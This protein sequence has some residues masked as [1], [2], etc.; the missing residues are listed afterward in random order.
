MFC[1]A[2]KE[3]NSDVVLKKRENDSST[4]IESAGL[5]GLLATQVARTDYGFMCLV[6]NTQVKSVKSI[7]RHLRDQHL[8]EDW[9]YMCPICKKMYRNQSSLYAHI[10]VYHP[11]LKGLASDQ[12]RVRND[13]S[14]K[15]SLL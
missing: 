2:R 11:D 1:A 9:S 13:G 14:E 3:I 6:C 4:I 7:R 15:A 5:T 8:E 10:H 12:C